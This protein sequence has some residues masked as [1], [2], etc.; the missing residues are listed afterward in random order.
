[1]TKF[2]REVFD[3]KNANWEGLKEELR[4]QDWDEVMGEGDISAQAVN[5]TSQC[6]MSIRNHIPSKVITITPLTWYSDRIG[7]MRR[8]KC[9]VH[10]TAKNTNTDENWSNFRRIRHKLNKSIRRA[11]VKQEEKMAKKLRKVTDDKQG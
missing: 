7:K 3:Y 4:L 9:I 1:M 6:M 8:K 11:Q 2:K 5:W 10:R